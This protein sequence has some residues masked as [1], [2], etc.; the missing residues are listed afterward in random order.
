[1]ASVRRVGDHTMTK[2]WNGNKSLPKSNLSPLFSPRKR[3]IYLT[4]SLGKPTTELRRRRRKRKTRFVKKRPKKRK[5]IPQVE[6]T[7][8]A[9]E[10]YRKTWCTSRDYSLRREKTGYWKHYVATN[11]LA[12]TAKSLR[13]WSVK[14]K[15][16]FNTPISLSGYMS[17]LPARKTQKGVSELWMAR[18]MVTGS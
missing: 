7:S 17:L 3:G 14:G 5:P 9:S 4:L 2:Q 11:I 16:E 10:W 13:S 18:R 6:N 15:R 1:M 12:S 8:P